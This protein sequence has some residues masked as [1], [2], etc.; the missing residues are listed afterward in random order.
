MDIL[1]PG[2]TGDT[3]LTLSVDKGSLLVFKYQ[4]DKKVLEN[5]ADGDFS[6]TVYF[7]LSYDY[8]GISL[9]D[10]Q[11]EKGRVYYTR[12]FFCPRAGVLSVSEGY[13]KAEKMI[14]NLWSVS[15][16]LKINTGYG[17]RKVIFEHTFVGG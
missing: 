6:E 4:Y 17:S 10:R 2:S 11:L 12:S 9:E 14:Q 7:Q 1:P 13:L 5:I 3:L 15:V 8:G 16:S